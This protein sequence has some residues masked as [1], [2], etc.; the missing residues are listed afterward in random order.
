LRWHDGDKGCGQ[1]KAKATKRAI[2]MATR[3]ASD[4]EGSGYGYK[5]GKQ[6]TATRAMTVATTVVGKDE[7]NG[8]GDEGGGQ[9]RG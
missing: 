3:L 8:N 5:G 1:V 7:G 9:R 6:V 2:A 4:N